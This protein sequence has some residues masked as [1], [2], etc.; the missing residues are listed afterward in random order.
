MCFT[1]IAG[2]DG[3]AFVLVSHEGVDR[4]EVLQTLRRRRPDVVVK[5]FEQEAPTLLLMVEDAADLARCRPG[6]EPLRITI[7]PQRGPGG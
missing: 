1:G 4:Q 2:G 6:V 5:C 3:T 7:M